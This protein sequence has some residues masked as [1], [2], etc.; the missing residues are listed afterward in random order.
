MSRKKAPALKEDVSANLI[1]MIDIMF[2]LLLFF[3]LGADMTQRELAELVLPTAD[4]V[5]ED[6]KE[7][8]EDDEFRTTLNVHHRPE[9]AGFKCAVNHNN[10]VCRDMEHWLVVIRSQEYDLET[11]NG[12]IKEMADDAL[13]AE[14][15][16][17]ANR[18]LSKVKV[19][20][21]ADK[22]APYGHVQQLIQMCGLAGIYKIEVGA[23]KPTEG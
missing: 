6:K 4:Q 7:K 23:A 15:N 2:L 20:I 19:S 10:Q 12:K 17:L 11:V 3:M 5:V 16:P 14:V 13:E 18:R 22:F 9:A 1:A 8:A 21:R